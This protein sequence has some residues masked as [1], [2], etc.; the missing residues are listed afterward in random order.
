LPHNIDGFASVGE[1]V[2][3]LPSWSTR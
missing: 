1:F 3:I 2:L